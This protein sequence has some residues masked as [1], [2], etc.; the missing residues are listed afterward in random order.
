MFSVGKSQVHLHFMS[1]LSIRSGF[2]LLI[3]IFIQLQNQPNQSAI[4][5]LE[6]DSRDWRSRPTPLPSTV[7]LRHNGG[8]QYNRQDQQDLQYRRGTFSSQHGVNNP[9]LKV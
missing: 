5:Q 3:C 7:D 9:N 1:S 8:N 2:S 4:R 6:P